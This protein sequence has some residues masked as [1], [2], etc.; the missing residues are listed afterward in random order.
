MGSREAAS[1]GLTDLYIRFLLLIYAISVA[2]SSTTPDMT[3]VF[4]ARSY[5]RFIDIKN[6]F[7]RK[8]L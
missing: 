6:S 2:A 8:T 3:T 5:D 7:R 4:Q 1:E